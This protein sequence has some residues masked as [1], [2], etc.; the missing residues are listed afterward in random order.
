MDLR[1]VASGLSVLCSRVAWGLAGFQGGAHNFARTIECKHSWRLLDH[2]LHSG[3]DRGI[4]ALAIL[5]STATM[6]L[7]RGID[8]VVAQ[9][10]ACKACAPLN[11]EAHVQNMFIATK[12]PVCSKHR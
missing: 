1:L 3:V 9:F 8:P 6:V 2:E 10:V 5:A 7:Y 12:T 4:S 11:V